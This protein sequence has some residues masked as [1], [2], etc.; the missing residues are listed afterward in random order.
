[1]N[2][3]LLYG[4][5]MVLL[6]ACHPA[7]TAH[8]EKPVVSVSILPQQYF[9]E[10]LA[11]ERVQVNVMIPP[12][13]SPAVYEPTVSQMSGLG[14]SVVYMKIGYVGFELGWMEKICA[15]HPSMKVVDLSEGIELIRGDNPTAQE[16]GHEHDKGHHHGGTDPHIWMSVRN[17]RLI[18]SHIHKSLREL[19]PDEN[20]VLDINYS[21]LMKDLDSLD[22]AISDMLGGLEQSSF[23]IYH[24]SLSYFARDYRLVQLPLELEGKSPSPGHMKELADQGREKGISTIFLQS[25]FDQNNAMALAREI[26]ATVVRI[27]PLDPDWFNQMLFIA[28]QL[29]ETL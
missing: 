7:T 28:N 21:K 19:L 25:Q 23:M 5:I 14:E 9:I 20:D 12:G 27:D 18:A 4:S 17:A 13:A 24:P 1:M 8:Q 29:K 3:A 22:M 26:G 10:R 2:K 15:A 6:V 11:G 16:H